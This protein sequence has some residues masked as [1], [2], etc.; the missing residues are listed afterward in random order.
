MLTKGQGISLHHDA[1]WLGMDINPNMAGRNP[2][3]R[4]MEKEPKFS[5]REFISVEVL[6]VLGAR[7]PHSSQATA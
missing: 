3:N 2:V 1:M 5:G 4:V 6:L 7:A